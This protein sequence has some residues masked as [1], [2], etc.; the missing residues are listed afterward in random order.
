[1]VVPDP[2]SAALRSA[3][4]LSWARTSTTSILNACSQ[5]E[6]RDAG[7]ELKDRV[8]IYSAPP[9]FEADLDGVEQQLEA[10]VVD[11]SR[12]VHHQTRCLGILQCP[13]ITGSSDEYSKTQETRRLSQ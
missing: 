11:P 9:L 1:M 3:V 12:R 6:N 2:T 5:Y 7:V 13:S 8:T 10:L 4:S